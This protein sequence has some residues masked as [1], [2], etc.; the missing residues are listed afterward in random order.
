MIIKR[1]EVEIETIKEKTEH[2]ST[3]KSSSKILEYIINSQ[4]NHFDKGGLGFN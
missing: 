3:Q 4:R 2:I 1:L